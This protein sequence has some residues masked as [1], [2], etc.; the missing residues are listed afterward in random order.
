[1]KFFS[2]KHQFPVLLLIVTLFSAPA[3]SQQNSATH[4]RGKLWETLYNWGFIGD[5]GAWDYTETT[6]IGF[7]PGFPGFT[8]PTDE[9]MANNNFITDANFH[10][11]RSGPWIIAKDVKVPVP[12]DFSPEQKDFA[13][14]H[15]SLATGDNGV[16]NTIPPFKVQE[17]YVGTAGFDPLLPEE[18]NTITFNT[19]T[20]ITVTQRS[21]AWSY[22]GYHDFII[23]DY[24]FKNTGQMVV[25][26]VNKTFNVPQT[27]KE[28]WIVFHSGIN[29]STKGMINFH[30]NSDFLSSAAPA[31]GF[32]W[33]PGN[34]YFNYYNVENDNPNDGK[35]L[36]YYSRHYNG[37]REPAPWDKYGLKTNWQNL[38]S[39]DPGV[40][41]PELQDP[42][43]FGFEFLYR[44][45]PPGAQS[46]DPFDADPTYFNIYSDEGDKFAGKTV[47]FESFGLGPF[48]VKELYDFARHNKRPANNGNLYCWY[49]SSFGPYNLA[50]GD[51]VRIILAEV[52]GVMDLKEV[53]MGDP[54][55]YFPDSTIAAI[56]RNALAARNAVKWGFG[57]TVQ[58]INLAADVPEAPPAPNCSAANASKGLD[59]AEIA[60]Q[61]D[62]LAETS[63][64]TDGSGG[65]FY[66]GSTDLSGYRIYRGT[67]KRGI[68]DLVVDIPRAE[69][70]NYWRAD[71]N[72]YE[73]LDKNLQF[74]FESYYYVQAY[75]N[76]PRS[77]TSANGTKV[78]N[79]PELASDDYNRTPLVGAKPGPVDVSKGWDVFAAPNPFI[80]GDRD[81]SFGYPTEMKIEFRNLPEKAVIKIFSLSGDLIKTIQHGPDANGNLAGSASWD[82]RSEAGLLV[83]PGLYIYVVQSQTEGTVRSKFT[84]KLMIIR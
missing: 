30:H 35:G 8:Y 33:H 37:G 4:T 41:P 48:S 24:T 7:Y 18:M 28:V 59:T 83:A 53:M 52:A 31:G 10:N 73:Y 6:G 79:L 45:P 15:A 81:H 46:Q 65:I 21:M 11:F 42:S 62:K 5:P 67:D 78:N 69:M 49:T 27:L 55:H 40:W 58:G 71:L 57:A 13:I 34:G 9:Q 36:L 77:W 74:G 75:N 23:Y 26:S 38:L 56:R 68:W 60:V 39:K 47:D 12:P 16:L 63:K 43:A 17:N 32:G 19:A 44:T 70:Q 82:Q 54:K 76:K 80:A 22:P 84:G 25:S 66:D 64:I 50:V 72:K 3:F 1:M 14:Y 61:W 29:V 2:I 20:G 51:S